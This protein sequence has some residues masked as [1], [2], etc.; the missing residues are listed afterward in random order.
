MKIL[1]SFVMVLLISGLSFNLKSQPSAPEP[2]NQTMAD[3]SQLIAS[4]IVK[5]KIPVLIDFW[6]P[7]CAPCRMLNP[8]IKELEKEFDGKIMFVKVNV[9]IHRGIA[10][11]FKVSSI[12]CIFLVKDKVVVKL[13]PGLQPKQVYADALNEILTAPSPSEPVSPQKTDK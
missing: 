12:P 1:L 11:Y 13:I 2:N 3:S 6:A 9:D 5:S 7:W 4:E 8:I 10:A